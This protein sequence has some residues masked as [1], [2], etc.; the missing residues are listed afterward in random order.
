MNLKEHEGKELFKEMGIPVLKGFVVSDVSQVESKIDSLSSSEVVVKV[1]VLTGGRGKAGGI[2]VVA[3]GDVND[4][5]SSLLGMNIKDFTVDEVLI[6]EKGDFS[7]E[8]YVSIAVN[9]VEKCLQL[10][11]C[12][13]GGVDIE[14]LSAKYPDK[15]ISVPLKSKEDISNVKLDVPFAEELVKVITQ[16][17]DLAVKYDA[18][19][20]EINPLVVTSDGLIAL[21]SKVVIDDNALFRHPEFS[22]KKE[23]ELTSIEK[24]ANQFG[25][26]YVELDGDIAI[27]GN[28]AGLVM[29]T[30]DVL[31]HF[32]GNPA[33]F[34]DVGGGASV[35]VME[36]SL[37]LCMMK[38]PAGIFVNIFGGITRC[39]FI[40]QGIVD[41]VG[42]QSISIPLVVRLIGT[43]E[44]EGQKILEDAGISSLASMEECAK[45]IVELVK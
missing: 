35:E 13:E 12:M 37:G 18:E 36:K 42:K 5:V 27:I 40:A 30:L 3:K 44:E 25:I 33:N 16:V 17:Y 28:G 7:Q 38:K 31:K 39:D 26:Q 21:D 29:G 11:V 15:I 24:E 22:G 2:K 43:N 34:L 8:L 20:V 19:L 4:A 23:V 14:E 9:R 45:K 1:Q 32:G 6:E 10:I 41:Y